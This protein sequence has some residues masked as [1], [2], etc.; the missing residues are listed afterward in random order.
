MKIQRNISQKIA[1]VIALVFEHA[2]V[3][4]E[5]IPLVS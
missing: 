3:T 5:I 1:R 2:P 4:S